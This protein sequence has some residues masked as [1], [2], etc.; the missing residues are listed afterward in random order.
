MLT[1]FGKNNYF[2]TFYN[3]SK[4]ADK[5]VILMFDIEGRYLSEKYEDK[6]IE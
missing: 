5:E 2:E 3:Y 6:D 4:I 1:A